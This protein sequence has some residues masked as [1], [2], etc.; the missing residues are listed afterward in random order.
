MTKRRPV[1]RRKTSPNGSKHIYLLVPPELYDRLWNATQAGGFR[2]EQDKILN[3]L[4]R[5]LEPEREQQS[6]VA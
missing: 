5:D 2:N 6:M 1:P 4:R 3:V